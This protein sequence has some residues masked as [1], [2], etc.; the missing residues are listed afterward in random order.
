M[1]TPDTPADSD[2]SG[3][4]SLS[5][6]T[7]SPVPAELPQL[8]TGHQVCQLLNIHRSTLAPWR[9]QGA[10]EAVPLPNG[11]WRYP[12][13]QPLIQRALAAVRGAQ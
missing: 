6:H 11:G 10:L 9:D 1:D 5:A 12:T 13:G 2:Q 7:V 8:L 4:Q 3:E